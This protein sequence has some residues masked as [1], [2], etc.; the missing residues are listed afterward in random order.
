MVPAP[1]L[2]RVLYTS[3]YSLSLSC[4]GRLYQPGTLSEADIHHYWFQ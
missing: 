1:K 4:R 3:S 2:A